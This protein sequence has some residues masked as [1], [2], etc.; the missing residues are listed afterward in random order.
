[1][2]SHL[3]IKN[4]AIIEKL[5]L[6]FEDGFTALTGETGAG[7]SILVGA[8]SLILGGRASVEM[9]RSEAREA[10]VEAI[11][12]LSGVQEEKTRGLLRSRG[13]ESGEQLIIRRILSRTG[14]NKVFING[15]AT[16][17]TLLQRLAQVLVD[18]IGQHASYSLLNS[19]KH[20]EM[21]DAFGGLLEDASRVELG[22]EGLR[23]LERELRSLQGSERER[24][25]RMDYLTFQLTEIEEAEIDR[26]RDE[27]LA[28][29][30]ELLRN[31]GRLTEIAREACYRLYDGERSIADQVSGVCDECK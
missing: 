10:V 27:E 3:I 13:I 7:K 20:V 30:Q 21:L 16:R 9:I 29:E 12:H 28:Q 24:L 1:M 25:S 15:S 18:V 26:E 11:F 22:V 6:G 14:R 2:L 31:A 8:L 17:V 19:G 23:G 4:F 5:E